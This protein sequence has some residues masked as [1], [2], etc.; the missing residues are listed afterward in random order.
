LD[1]GGLGGGEKYDQDLLCKNILKIS[2]VVMAHDF[3]LSSQEAEAG[4]SL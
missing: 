3:N 4:G 2:Q 1:V